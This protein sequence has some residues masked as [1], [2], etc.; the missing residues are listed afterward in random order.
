M[1]IKTKFNLGDSVYGIS[2][3]HKLI[4]FKVGKIEA[5]IKPDGIEISYYPSDG[6]NGYLFSS[7]NEKYSFAEAKEALEYIVN[8]R[9]I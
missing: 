6:E 8:N 7:F 2:F 1:E 9:S 3:N 5:S 4:D